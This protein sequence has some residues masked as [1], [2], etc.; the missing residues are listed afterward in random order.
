[1]KSIRTA[2]SKH[3]DPV[4][5]KKTMFPADARLATEYDLAKVEKHLQGGKTHD[6]FEHF[7]V[8]IESEFLDNNLFRNGNKK[9]H[10]RHLKHH[11]NERTGDMEKKFIPSDM[12]RASIAIRV[13]FDNTKTN[14]MDIEKRLENQGFP[15]RWIL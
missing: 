6:G 11:A 13:N 10:I 9:I 3:V 1:M 8:W 5:M 4:F 7:P 14:P 2:V 12:Q 15:S